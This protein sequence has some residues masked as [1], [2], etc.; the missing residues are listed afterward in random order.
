MKKLLLTL[1]FLLLCSTSWAATYYVDVDSVGG[2][3]STCTGLSPDLFDGSGTGEACAFEHP[4]W[5]LGALGTTGVMS[6]GDTLII[7]DDAGTAQ[8]MIGYGMAN[9]AGC[10]SSARYNCIMN[11]PPSGSPTAKTKIYGS[12]WNTGC[13]TKPQLWG[14]EGVVGVFNIHGAKANIEIQCIEV[15][16]H[17]ACN[18]LFGNNLCNTNWAST[19]SVGTW[20]RA[21]IRGNQNA[22]LTMKNVD[23][24]GMARQGLLIGDLSGTTLFDHVN[25]DGNGYNGW[26]GDLANKGVGTNT[27]SINSGTVFL[28]YVNIRYNGYHE[29][30]PRSA[31]FTAS[32]YTGA[33]DQS[34]SNDG[35]GSGTTSGS[36]YITNSNISHNMSDGLDLRYC[37]G[38]ANVKVDKSV[39]E[40][41]TGNQFKATTVNLDLDNSIFIGNC[42]Y[43]TAS[44]KSYVTNEPC[45]AGGV[46]L[47]LGIRAGGTYK[48]TNSTVY[49]AVDNDASAVFEASNIGG[50]A[51]GTE[52]YTF[53]NNMF[54]GHASS[55]GQKWV[56]YYNVN[57]TGAA[58]TD[59]TNASTTYSLVYNFSNNP[60]GTGN[61]FIAPAWVGSISNGAASNIANIMLTSN[62]G[63][64]NASTYWNNSK[65]Y[66]GF[67]QLADIDKGALQ[68]GTSQQLAASGQACIA[69]SDCASG[70]CNNFTCSGSCTANGGACAS[71]A[72][73]CSSYCNG[74]SLCAVPPTC[75]DGIIQNPEICDTLGP[76]VTGSNCI[77]QGF[78]GG[79]LGCTAGCASYDTSACTNTLVFPLT[80]IL[81]NFNRTNEGPPMTGWT[82]IYNGLKVVSNQAKG[83]IADFN[84]S[85]Y[86][87][88]GTYLDAEAYI[89]VV[90]VGGASQDLYLGVRMQTPISNE[91]GYFIYLKKSDN[92]LKLLR[93]QSG[94]DAILSS[95]SQTVSNGD[96]IG[97]SVVGSAIKGYYKAAAGSWTLVTSTTDTT[98]PLAGGIEISENGTTYVLDNLGGGSINPVVC[99]NSL[100]EAGEICDDPDADGIDLAGQSCLTLNFAS[101]TLACLSNCTAF[102]TSG[103]V[104][105]SV[106]GNNTVEPGELCDGTDTGGLTCATVGGGFSS[107]TLACDSA[108]PLCQTYDTSGCVTSSSG[109]TGGVTL[110]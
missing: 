108:D 45:R 32:D 47:Y 28:N 37:T 22:N 4:V 40:G 99:G 94:P 44:G 92:T 56:P 73:C 106:C 49:S 74:S 8:Y 93:G 98:Y 65:D 87:V 36:W 97:I 1:S 59:L 29:A 68:Y 58:A 72:T 51:N 48:I 88:G 61:S 78:T 71:G 21:G 25:S 62:I 20:G 100:V 104:T 15:T 46:T 79:T 96:S 43:P 14:T 85:N 5:A 64:G 27:S 3:T 66:Y 52:T 13:A 76:V 107:G 84:V 69:T 101:G 30:Y 2:N 9:T 77:L 86:T 89:T 75:G 55:S 82:D 102:D 50:T 63:G 105:A 10:T 33:S 60:A 6:G 17:S 90:T 23:V 26:E 67:A 24:H 11:A 12:A 35:I 91:Y 103:C 54:V 18:E 39:F 31:S 34:Q 109:V 38:C 80:P 19:G 53:K 57:L 70:T 42:N 16:D 41:N 7:D 110:R 83:N 95:V 81:D